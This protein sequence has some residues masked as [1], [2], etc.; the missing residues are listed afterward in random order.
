ML[1]ASILKGGV[2]FGD[3]DL[4]VFL[5][6]RTGLWGGLMSVA[7]EVEVRWHVGTEI[8]DLETYARAQVAS[9]RVADEFE[10]PSHSPPGLIQTIESIRLDPVLVVGR[11]PKPAPLMLHLVELR[12]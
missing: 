12:E 2:G 7:G 3:Q 5:E 6:P 8:K 4:E 11:V 10:V 9:K 1:R